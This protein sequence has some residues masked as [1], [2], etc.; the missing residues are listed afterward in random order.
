MKAKTAMVWAVAAGMWGACVLGQEVSPGNAAAGAAKGI[1]PAEYP[2]VP[3]LPG[4]HLNPDGNTITLD[5]EAIAGEEY[6]I[7][8]TTNLLDAEW[9]DLCHWIAGTNG[10][11]AVEVAVPSWDGSFFRIRCFADMGWDG[12]VLSA[13]V[14]GVAKIAIPA[15]KK[16]AMS[17]PFNNPSNADGLFRF[18]E[19]DIAKALPQGSVVYFWD[20]EKQTWNG[21][22]KSSFGWDP[23]EANHVLAPGEG[24]C[25]LNGGNEEVDVIIAG[26]VPSDWQLSRP[27]LGNNDLRVMAEPY[28]VVRKF[29]DTELA[30]Q[31]W[32]GTSVLFW[33]ANGQ[34]WNSGQ[35][36]AK[37]W[38]AASSNHVLAVGEAF[39]IKPP[40]E[41]VWGASKPYSWP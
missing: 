15:G 20:E 30:S 32:Q 26:E 10:E 18:G 3:V 17:V 6:G 23:A 31:V 34:G 41:G 37:G 27:Y 8:C 14:F 19:T 25:V 2:D 21:G 33:D 39:F 16:Q 40:W 29:G 1:K 11:A 36:G 12:E 35:K 9:T 24:F 13:N 4:G 7:E 38:T 5:F 22:M 28:P